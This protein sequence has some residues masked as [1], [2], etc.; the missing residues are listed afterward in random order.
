MTLVWLICIFSIDLK[1][2]LQIAA[3]IA[4]PLGK[5]QEIV[6]INDGSGGN[7][8]SSEITKLV[9]QLPPAVQALTGIDL[10]K[11][12]SACTISPINILHHDY[13]IYIYVNTFPLRSLQSYHP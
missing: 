4:A 11:V 3:E 1:F 12:C 2:F 5:T 10:S 13:I 7:K 6:L 9:G 8:L